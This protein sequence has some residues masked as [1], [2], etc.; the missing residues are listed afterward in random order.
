MIPSPVLLPLVSSRLGGTPPPTFVR[1]AFANSGGND[2]TAVLNNPAH[3]FLTLDAAVDALAVAY[4]GLDTTIQ[5]QTD[6]TTGLTD[7]GNVRNVQANGLTLRS[8]EDV[9]PRVLSGGI[10]LGGAMSTINL[11]IVS[12][13]IDSAS[14]IGT[15]LDIGMMRLTN[16]T[17]TS[18]DISGDDNNGTD[19]GVGSLSGG[20]PDGGAKPPPASP[21]TAGT[22]GGDATFGGSDGGN[23]GSA[24]AGSSMTIVGSGTITTLDARGGNANGGMGGPGSD[25]KG[26]DG[27]PGGDSSNPDD[28]EAGGD[29][30]NGGNA[31]SSGARGGAGGAAGGGGTITHDAGVVITS[32]LV[33]GGTATGG[34]GGVPATATAGLGALGGDGANAGPAGNNGMNGTAINNTGATGTDGTPG[35]NGS[36]VIT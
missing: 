5:L 25:C 16:A 20:T 36:E 2:G 14:R 35:S 22:N 6:I 31:D 19:S 4:V 8:D 28:P 24:Q 34:A 30:G 29:G 32:L 1:T 27:Q 17:I 21:A 23:A 13:T 9:A 33:T 26:G 3:P 12:L 11:T 7:S 10:P 15:G 18:L